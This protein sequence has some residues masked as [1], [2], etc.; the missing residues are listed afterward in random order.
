MKNYLESL[1]NSE[2]Y[3]EWIGNKVPLSIMEKEYG[4]IFVV[5]KKV[6]TY[7]IY[8]FF[9]FESSDGTDM[10]WNVS[11]DIQDWTA[12]EVIEFLLKRSK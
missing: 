1:Q 4:T 5:T 7:S 12:D 3:K 6:G 10:K 8:R 9:P 2:I 11:A